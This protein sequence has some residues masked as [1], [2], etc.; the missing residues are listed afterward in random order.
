MSLPR[1][2]SPGLRIFLT[3]AG[4]SAESGIPTFRGKEGYWTVGAQ[5][6]HPQE[7]ATHQAF[8]EMPYEVWAWYLY[9]RDVCRA[10][11]PNAG[12]QAL[13]QAE[14]L[15]GDQFLLVTQNVDG[16]HLRAGNSP[17]RTYEVHGNIDYFRCA[18]SCTP[19]RYPL[20]EGFLPFAKGQKV[21]PEQ[22]ALLVCPRCGGRARPHVLWFDEC[23]NEEFYRFDSSRAAAAKAVALVSVGT[24][25][26]TNLPVQM[27]FI[28]AQRGTFL[29]DINPDSN[30]FSQ[31]AEQ[32]GGR[33]LRESASTGLVQVMRAIQG[34]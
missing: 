12:H 28:A 33:W 11:P 10:A 6:Y 20:G 19:E 8:T 24:S 17:E 13:V 30:P 7:L 32:Q 34:G 21:T 18:D 14:R 29:V 23:Y 31:L 15:L 27:G 25:G 9:R 3:G 26:N 2:A 4:I 22:Q 16:L 1:L 5:E